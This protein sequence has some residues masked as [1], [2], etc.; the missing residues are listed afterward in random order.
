MMGCKFYNLLFIVYAPGLRSDFLYATVPL[1]YNR[2]Y[3]N[4]TLWWPFKTIALKSKALVYKYIL[5]QW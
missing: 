1:F 4:F 3:L 5:V 2:Q